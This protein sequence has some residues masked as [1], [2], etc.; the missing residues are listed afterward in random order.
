[1]WHAPEGKT[2]FS[3][4]FALAL[5]YC[6]WN[7]SDIDELEVYEHGHLAFDRLTTDQ[8][9]WTIHQVA[10][11]LLDAKTEIV[12]LMAYVEATVATIF[13]QME[14]DINIEIQFTKDD[15]DEDYYSFRRV[16]LA[17]YEQVGGNSPDLL[18]DNEEPL[19]VECDIL[20]EWEAAVEILETNILWDSDYD[21]DIFDDMP[22]QK[23]GQLKDEFGILDDYFTSVPKDPKRS[24]TL[25]LL[26]ETQKLCDRV[27][28]RE[29]KKFKKI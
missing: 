22:P 3:G 6:I 5:A 8:K 24:E 27:I 17:A 18:I 28:K 25:K 13:R 26:K 29:E 23:S 10:F 1:M 2:T 7:M 15:H 11:G 12:P 20:S 19:R 9:A 4:P 14:E 21:L 16:V